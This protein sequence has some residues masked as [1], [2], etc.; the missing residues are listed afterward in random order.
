VLR[1]VAKSETLGSVVQFHDMLLGHDRGVS[2]LVRTVLLLSCFVGTGVRAQATPA[3]ASNADTRDSTRSAVPVDRDALIAPADLP[4]GHHDI[5][6]DPLF[7]PGAV[8]VG[9]GAVALL[10]SLL[11]GLGAHSLYTSLE[12]NCTN[13]VCVGPQVQR[14]DSGR[15]LAVVSTVLTGVGIGAAGLGAA[16][17]IIAG[18]R[19]DKPEPSLWGFS[20]L[21]WTNG[22]TPLGLGARGNF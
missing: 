15:T 5:E 11:T 22:P 12:R 3:P 21:R 19:E 20:G 14:I 8:L 16:L 2:M 1:R 18:T 13:N 7:V 17:L 6:S 4:K 9:T 10:T